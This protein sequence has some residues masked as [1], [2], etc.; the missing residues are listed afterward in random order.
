MKLRRRLHSLLV[1]FLLT[2][3]ISTQNQD[4]CTRQQPTLTSPGS[5]STP[6]TAT[7]VFWI[8]MDKSKDRRKHMQA[9]LDAAGYLNRRVKG[10]SIAYDLYFPT[11]IKT[12]WDKI[13][14][15]I[16]TDEDI[17]PRHS[18][19]KFLQRI[20]AGTEGPRN[21]TYVVA[22][23]LGRSKKNSLK[24]VGCTASHLEAM[25]QAIYNNRSSSPYALIMEDDV[26]IPFNIDFD[27]LAQSAPTQDF[28]ILQLFNS[29]EE[30]MHSSWMQYVK[31][32]N[33]WMES[34][35]KQ[36][37]SFWSTCAY[38]INREVMRPIID[39]IAYED[40]GWIY[41][42]IVAGIVKPCRPK[43][44]ACCEP[45]PP[46]S[47]R[48]IHEPPCIWAA[49][50]F[51]ADSFIYALA[52]TYVLT[53]PIITNSAAGN[54]STFH[55][56]H[57]VSVHQSAFARQRQYIN[58][59]IQGKYELPE[60]V[61]KACTRPLQVNSVRFSS[62]S[63]GGGSPVESTSGGSG[64]RCI[65]ADLSEHMEATPVYWI[66]NARD[67]PQ[68]RNM[69][70]Y[71]TETIRLPEMQIVAAT[72]DHLLIPEDLLSTWEGRDCKFQSSVLQPVAA[73]SSTEFVAHVSLPAALQEQIKDRAP[74]VAEGN[75]LNQNHIFIISGLCGRGKGQNSL[76]DLA[77]TMSHLHAIHNAVRKYEA[78][79]KLGESSPV[80]VSRHA[81]ILE[82]D[83]QFLFDIDFQAMAS[84]APSDFGILRLF[85]SHMTAAERM[86]RRYERSQGDLWSSTHE[87]LFDSW[88]TKAYLIDCEV[89]APVI[90]EV[91]KRVSYA[92]SAVSTAV[93][94][95]IFDVK[96]IG[97]LKSPCIPATC[98]N[99]SS[100]GGVSH[101][102]FINMAP[103]FESTAGFL[104]QK[105][106]FRLAPTYVLH[107]PLFTANLNGI[108][109]V[110]HQQRLDP[111][112]M[113]SLRKQKDYIQD[114]VANP[115]KL[116][117]FVRL[118]NST[119]SWTVE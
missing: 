60:F 116:P 5:S 42:K 65:R 79:Q 12:N 63:S 40:R 28:G 45:Q 53:I 112:D 55:Q 17:P 10:L 108:A 97:G 23:L 16:M 27:K 89:L 77:I 75:D 21:Y 54:Q 31:K 95:Q 57:V 107:I 80:I 19:K 81:L 73:H 106:L 64:S 46:Y 69:R 74:L 85:T 102:T 67:S 9:H 24:E 8:N 99:F 103:C 3:R 32:R 90:K 36:A 117:P 61:S 47:F 101:P 83:V 98:C 48:F 109:S 39:K 56:D 13:G 72:P 70:G 20:G 35:Q 2:L 82:D 114:L 33:L 29:N 59:L 104:A 71:L 94:L 4:D 6:I 38:L 113:A 37:A 43:H 49:K 118:C 88:A 26:F 22:G 7:E 110:M 86:W 91:M 50:G 78:A 66:T 41:L 15:K 115:R 92:A 11:D 105:L 18:A 119:V 34:H 51:Q 14:A 52:K 1:L 62:T 58:E 84:T 93:P 111:S 76:N 25:R 96:V 30:S 87:K 44:S 100:S 68:A